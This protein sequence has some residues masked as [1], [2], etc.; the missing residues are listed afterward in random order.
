MPLPLMN[1]G[2]GENTTVS[3]NIDPP[4]DCDSDEDEQAIHQIKESI[5]TLLSYIKSSGSFATGGPIRNI[6]LPG[7]SIHDVSLIALPLSEQAAKDII[8]VC[9]QAPYGKGSDT[10]VDESVR[11]TWE[12]NPDLFQFQNPAW[13][14]NIQQ[15]A[16]NAATQLGISAEASINAELYKLLLYE[17]GAMFKPHQ[18]YI[19]LPSH[20]SLVSLPSVHEGGELVARHHGDG[21]TFATATNSAYQF[22]YIAWYADVMHEVRPIASG[23][24]LVVVYN[25]VQTSPGAVQ[26]AAKLLGEKDKLGTVFAA[27]GRG[28]KK[29]NA[30]APNFLLYQLEHEYTEESLKTNALKGL[31]KLKADCLNDVCSQNDVG[32]YLASCEKMESGGCAGDGYNRYDGYDDDEE[33]E[34]DDD[35]GPHFIEDVLDSSLQIKRLVD[36]DGD[37]V[38]RD[39]DVNE[40]DFIQDEPF[41]REPD[42]EDYEGYMGNSGQ[43]ATHFYYDSLA[44]LSA[45]YKAQPKG[46]RLDVGFSVDIQWPIKVAVYLHRPELFEE[47]LRSDRP[48][49]DEALTEIGK[50]VCCLELPLA[51][52]ETI[53]S[54]LLDRKSTFEDAFQAIRLLYSGAHSWVNQNTRVHGEQTLSQIHQWTL[55]YLYGR[56]E[57]AQTLSSKDG[58][59]LADMAIVYA[60]DGA[61]TRLAAICN[62]HPNNLAAHVSFVAR[63]LAN[64]QDE[65]VME[66]DAKEE[67]DWLVETVCTRFT[68]ENTREDT[69]QG[70]SSKGISS[71]TVGACLTN[72]A[73]V[74][75]LLHQ[76]ACKAEWSHHEALLK[77]LM[78]CIEHM[79]IELFAIFMPVLTALSIYLK[80]F[81]DHVSNYEELFQKM[82]EFYRIRYIQ[83]RPVGGT[84]ACRPHGCGRCI[85][86][87][88]LDAF[89][90]HP[91]QRI[92]HFAVSNHRRMHLH[93]LL[94]STEHNHVTNRASHPETLTVTKKQTPLHRGFQDWQSRVTEGEMLLKGLDPNL[95]QQLLGDKYA[96][97]TNLKGVKPISGTNE[98]AGKSLKR[99]AE[100]IDLT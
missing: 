25:L 61:L 58:R 7:L 38:G 27:W 73:H 82:L 1:P 45:S 62:E 86:C 55:S 91:S 13:N 11:K 5:D 92:E 81:P 60:R 67:F 41:A 87:R 15:L 44:K 54:A 74:V 43:D 100:V 89:L 77:R 59:S 14:P 72:P 84:W 18:E 29:Q 51:K 70:H 12:L 33:E 76:L 97:L 53:L 35:D 66:S 65:S 24:R 30:D 56:L 2:T 17:E 19:I 3:E 50:G 96:E 47:S 39:I 21:K 42:H 8:K 93:Q 98:S 4:E 23:Y 46:Y 78:H 6:P 64:D 48:V 28:I 88:K 85:D 40:E 83:P 37:L 9:H 22:N 20:P 99:K 75:L 31:D 94:N 52:L 49:S 32:C 79:R 57:K 71:G 95:L 10:L 90:T 80:E 36:L 69:K 26:T 68:L 63:F 34:D 16:R